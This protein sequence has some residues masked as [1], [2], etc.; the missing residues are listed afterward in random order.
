MLYHI[1]LNT[2]KE[3]LLLFLWEDNQT[4]GIRKENTLAYKGSLNRKAKIIS[5]FGLD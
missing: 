1:V 2:V 3:I 4:R 5:I